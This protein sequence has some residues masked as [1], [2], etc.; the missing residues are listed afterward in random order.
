MNVNTGALETTI[1]EPLYLLDDENNESMEK[2]THLQP[3]QFF[4]LAD[5]SEQLIE[6]L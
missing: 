3:W 4:L 5:Q 6:R 2:T 1:L